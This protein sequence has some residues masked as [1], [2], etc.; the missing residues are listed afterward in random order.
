MERNFTN[1]NFEG[2]LRQN[3]DG[4]RMRPSDKVW[5]GISRN[6]NRK[7]RRFGFALVACLLIATGS[8]YYFNQHSPTGTKASVTQPATSISNLA[9]YMAAG[10]PS[11]SH[12]DKQA[13]HQPADK[14]TAGNNS[15]AFNNSKTA[16]PVNNATQTT[17]IT[18][19][20]GM[21]TVPEFKPAIVDSYVEEQQQADKT[22]ETKLASQDLY[23]QTIESVVNLYK[24]R[25]KKYSTQLYFT[26]SVSYRR[27]SDNL[28]NVVT[29][30]PDFGF[31]VGYTVKRAV[32]KTVKLRAG[33]Q[34][35]VLRY[36]IKTYNSS[37]E[38]ATI[39]LN[40]RNRTESVSTP[41]NYNNISGYKSNW[42]QNFYFQV[43]APVGM[44]LKLRGDDKVQFGIA[45][46]LQPTYILGDRAYLISTDYKNYAEVP[47]LIRHMNVNTSLET[48]VAYST[49]HLQWQV[50]PQ[51]RYQLF[52][53]FVKKYPVKE[54]LFDFGLKVGISVNK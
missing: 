31:E 2:F 50:G 1:E 20:A 47:K 3:A 23:P 24:S 6:L 15:L 45:S 36:D 48:F 13:S 9:T 38:V 39:R 10:K 43:S 49:G 37:T 14:L 26:P 54:N 32:S 18:E 30:K 16:Y 28:E 7:R 11:G 22:A 4:L 52:S 5:K 27:L 34:F 21:N 41:T 46:T 33:L 35:N 8:G 53:S 12:P 19:T 51:V 25:K 17:G 42:L 44:E 40:A 29:H